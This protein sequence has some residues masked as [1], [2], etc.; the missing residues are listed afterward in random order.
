MFCRLYADCCPFIGTGF[1]L[2][3]FVLGMTNSYR[4]SISGQK[5]FLIIPVAEETI[6]NKFRRLTTCLRFVINFAY[7]GYG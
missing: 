3:H 7:L 2:N 6:T 4:I 5:L 1:C